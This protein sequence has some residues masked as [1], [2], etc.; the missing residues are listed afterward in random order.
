VEPGIS[1]GVAGDGAP[2]LLD[3]VGTFAPAGAAWRLEWWIG[4]DDRWRVPA[5]E[6]SVRQRRLDDSPV[7]ETAMRVPGG[8][9]VE[10]VY[11]VAEPGHPVVVE[12][13]NA[14]PAAFVVAFAI[15]GATRVSVDGA[16]AAVDTAFVLRTPRAPS[17]WARTVGTPV[18]LPVST[19]AAT[20]S[21][22]GSV[23]DRAG[24]LEVALLHPVAHRTTL[25]AALTGSRNAPAVDP[26]ALPAAATVAR[27]WR[28]LLERGLRTDL[29]DPAVSARISAARAEV[30]LRAQSR[31]PPAPVVAALED[32]GFDTEFDAAWRRLSGRDRRSAAQRPAPAR[33]SDISALTDDADFLLAVRRLLVDDRPEAG[34][35]IALLRDLPAPWRGQDLA[36]RDAPVRGGCCS[37]AVRWH[38][39]RAA[40]LWEA[41]EGSLLTAPGLDP[42]WSTRLARGEALLEA[43]GRSRGEA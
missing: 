17:R 5:N 20:D 1:V 37:Y 25:R 19:G 14:S 32:W 13:E 26:R 24:R 15:R 27:G 38:G 9:A 31:V 42:T 3:P 12:I 43:G 21:S 36:V 2:G 29:P 39:E 18:L 23:R 28:R 35:P 16:A 11:A 4:A 34:A 10:R 7:V 40:L 41:P 8:D 30:L 33:W 22:F 6:V